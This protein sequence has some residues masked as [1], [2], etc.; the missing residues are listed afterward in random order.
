MDGQLTLQDALQA[1]V[2]AYLYSFSYGETRKNYYCGITDD[3]DRRAKEHNATF[4]KTMT[5]D[6]F[7]SAQKLEQALHDAGFDTG[8]QV[9]N[10]EEDSVYIYMYKK[11]PGVTKE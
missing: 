9:G 1:F 4:I 2:Q 10:G 3:L 6:R 5:A 7:E 8:K 11:I